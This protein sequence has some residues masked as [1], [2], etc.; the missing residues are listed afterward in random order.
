MAEPRASLLHWGTKR[1]ADCIEAHPARPDL[2]AVGTYELRKDAEGAETRHG[3]VQLLQT[4]GADGAP[5]A[6]AVSEWELP[7]VFDLKWRPLA[8]SG[9]CAVAGADGA[10]HRFRVSASGE[11]QS[12][13]VIAREAEDM[14]FCLSVGWSPAA[15]RIAFGASTGVVAVAP[16]D[17]SSAVASW[18]GHDQAMGGEVWVTAWMGEDLVLSGADDCRLK[19]WDPRQAGAAAWQRRLDAGVTA[20]T[21]RQD[22]LL[23][24]GGYDERLRCLDPRMPRADVWCTH[25]LGGGVWRVKPHPQ[26]PELLLCAAMQ[27]GAHVFRA[28]AAAAVPVAHFAAHESMVYGCEWLPGGRPRAATCSFYDAAL[29]LWDV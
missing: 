17:G 26:R 6:D 28:D 22:G 19:A 27:G 23:L 20:L 10:V 1:P 9:E 18:D 2:L 14:G 8:D 7:G 11:V 4:G 25:Q 3:L 13:G 21:P 5:S 15:D 16:V 12:V 24:V 29:H